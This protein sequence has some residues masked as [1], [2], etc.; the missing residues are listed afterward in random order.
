MKRFKSILSYFLILALLL[1]GLPAARADEVNRSQYLSLED[2]A[3][4]A[5]K[6]LAAQSKT[7]HVSFYLED[8]HVYSCHLLTEIFLDE[9]YKH[10]GVPDEG[11]YLKWSFQQYGSGATEVF[12]GT[13]HWV[14]VSISVLDRYNM[15]AE[16]EQELDQKLEQVMVSLELEG[17]SDYE[18]A[19]AIY[20][21]VCEHV[22]Y[23]PE[24]LTSDSNPMIPDSE[25][26]VYYS[27]Y[28]ALVLG[29]T[30]CQGYASLL[31]MMMLKAGLDCRII[32]GSN[33]GWNIV[34][35]DG[36]YYYLDATYDEGNVENP[37]RF[38][39][40][41]ASFRDKSHETWHYQFSSA[42][43][44]EYPISVLDYGQEDLSAAA[45]DTVIG[46]GKCG[47]NVEWELTADGR[48]TISGTGRMSNKDAFDNYLWP[49]FNGYIKSVEIGEGVTHIG[50]YA[51]Y[52]CP[53]LAEIK[54][55]ESVTSV[56]H[57]AFSLCESLRQVTLPDSVTTVGPSTFY[58]CAR[59]ESATLSAG[60]TT[61]PMEMFIG[62]K[63]LKTVVIPEG[64]R[65]IGEAAFAVCPS[66]GQ[67]RLPD[68]LTTLDSGVFI[69]SFD[70]EEKVSLTLPESITDIGSACFEYSGLHELIWNARTP[71]MEVA[72]LNL[73]HHLEKLTLSDTIISIEDAALC[74]CSNLKHL[75]L[76]EKLE[77]LGISAMESCASLTQIELPQT[78]K[79]VDCRAFR[80][81][82]ALQ[83]IT[84]PA[85]LS[86]IGK[87]VI[88][89][90]PNLLT[91]TFLGSAPDIIMPPDPGDDFALMH[92]LL[93]DQ[94]K[95]TVWYPD[96]DPTWTDEYKQELAGN[97]VRLRAFHEPGAEHTFASIGCNGES[98]WNT[99]KGCE[100]VYDLEPHTFTN[101]CDR[102]CEGCYYT[103]EAPHNFTDEWQYDEKEHWHVCA[104]CMNSGDKDSHQF[105]AGTTEGNIRTY[106]CTDCGYAVTEEIPPE[107]MASAPVETLPGQDAPAAGGEDDIG[108][109]VWIVIA[110]VAC[111]ACAGGVYFLLKKK[112]ADA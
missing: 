23:S 69:E 31:Y 8:P 39:R 48:M 79:E 11:D 78:L 32:A 101:N 97:D 37:E 40:G 36:K 84:F 57:Y 87:P 30:T 72:V 28:G 96:N 56:G 20:R 60:M 83:K 76:P 109:A 62:C 107:E 21:Y 35:I 14:D 66:L 9:V 74:G 2:A 82:R 49:G 44:N 42:F 86:K 67:I 41:S 68:T 17:K 102:T 15:T 85:S 29:R 22:A 63:D 88:S 81:C 52:N 91:I 95:R 46:S 100:E 111:A 98:H 10:T 59:L 89:L 73:C 13:T 108:G 54:I 65:K 6:S 90:C 34:R 104:D 51:F 61:I 106:T 105:D 99:C 1:P 50:D 110:V 80:D 94:I 26:N 103:R 71:R 12:D 7:V 19:S 3:E 45:P 16:Q 92:V 4:K 64:I 93:N 27:A 75:V 33:H 5:R 58:Q 25:L 77:T 47:A 112:K 18:K 55:A 43:L 53:Q 70:P 24:V 38:L